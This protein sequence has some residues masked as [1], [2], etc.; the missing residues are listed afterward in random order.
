MQ[1]RDFLRYGAA[2]LPAAAFGSAAVGTSAA[3]RST[4]DGDIDILNYALVLEYFLSQF[5]REGKDVLSG[6]DAELIERIG[7]DE[8]AHIAGITQTIQNLG[9]R[10][11]AAPAIDFGGALSSRNRLLRTSLRF[12]NL[13]AGAYLGAA[14]AIEN[15]DILQAAAGIF[16]VEERHAAI[17]ANLLGLPAAGGVYPGAVDR[18]VGRPEVLEAVRPFLT[19]PRSLVGKA[20]VTG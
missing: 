2:A 11:A 5:Y 18:P 10:P 7:A 16:G 1:R 3:A 19:S 9:G 17:V 8:D 13:F 15:K 12:E 14:G 20:A 6:R 4:F